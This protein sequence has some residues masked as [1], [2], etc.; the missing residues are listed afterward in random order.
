MQAAAA[1]PYNRG[2]IRKQIVQLAWP[3]I[4]EQI[5]TTLTNIID[6]ILV[7]HL[8]AVAVAAIGLTH[9]PHW[10]LVGL[11]AGIGVGV[12]AL[13]ARFYGAGET[14]H[15]ESA[16][17]AGFWLG[18]LLSLLAG[19]GV[20]A[21][22]PQILRA[23][24]AEPEVLPVGVTYL[25]YM[26][27]GQI[28]VNLVMPMTAALRAT[29][30]TRTPLVINVGVNLLNAGLAYALIYGFVGLPALGVAGAGIATSTAR[31]LGAG[32]L[33]AILL[34]RKEGA[35]LDWRKLTKVDWSL[36]G[37]IFNVGWVSSFERM[38]NTGIYIVYA[39]MINSQGTVVTAAQ[40]ITV[41]AENFSWFLASGF[42]MATAAM[43]GQRLGARRPDQAEAVIY[44]AVYMCSV[45]LGVLGLIFILVPG[46][47]MSIFTDDPQ[48]R[49][50]S[51]AAIRIAGITEI[52][53]AI[54]LTLN[55]ALSGA[56]DTR[57]LFWVNVGGGVV[58]LGVA[59][60]LIFGFDMGL[61]GAWTAA[62]CDWVVRAG[63]MWYRFRSGAW[64][65][66]RV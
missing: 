29:G 58:R 35:R 50:L 55:G 27:P 5:L 34:K 64:K 45:V 28:A 48:V 38:F 20:Y 22:A 56:G 10:L 18:L 21:F 26:V 41:T 65:E 7:G 60:L 63:L 3:V 24:L 8:G 31:V 19:A 47:Y 12:N 54:V 37:R 2:E 4:V 46:P 53:T 62:S 1:A 49:D 43:V 51:A 30:D 57:P 42:S 6:M 16:T 44:Q 32:V 66:I 9:T 23:V 36:A 14:G 11:F 61:Q 17:R 13:V 39:L 15:I 59:A 52:G 33:L 25:R 40:T